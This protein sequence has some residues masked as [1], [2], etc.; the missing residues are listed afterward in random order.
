MHQPA[1]LGHGV[2][3]PKALRSEVLHDA[4]GAVSCASC[5]CVSLSVSVCKGVGMRLCDLSLRLVAGPLSGRS[6]PALLFPVLVK[7]LVASVG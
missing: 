5:V 7:C 4:A 6:S 1:L 2:T 3:G